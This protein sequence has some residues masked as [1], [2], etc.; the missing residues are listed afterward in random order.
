MLHHL[1]II[2]LLSL[3]FSTYNMKLSIYIISYINC[4]YK[5]VLYLPKKTV[6][7][8]Q[9][10]FILLIWCQHAGVGFYYVVFFVFFPQNN[11]ILVIYHNVKRYICRY[12]KPSFW[13]FYLCCLNYIDSVL[14]LDSCAVFKLP[15]WDI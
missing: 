14:K 6:L 5:I 7:Y 8:S 1:H 10:G 9:N 2:F 12:C 3:Y 4:W 11:C 15:T 13:D